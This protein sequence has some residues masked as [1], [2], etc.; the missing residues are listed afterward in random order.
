MLPPKKKGI[1]VGDQVL[2]KQGLALTLPLARE[3]GDLGRA[4][5][6]DQGRTGTEVPALEKGEW[7]WG[8]GINKGRRGDIERGKYLR[9]RDIQRG[10][11]LREKTLWK[12]ED[13]KKEDIEREIHWEKRI[14]RG[15]NEYWEKNTLRG[16]KRKT[17][18][19]ENSE[20]NTLPC[21][22]HRPCRFY[23]KTLLCK[24]G[25]RGIWW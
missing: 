20:R 6:I 17:L 25:L 7:D 9:R 16:W 3:R 1:G 12:G 24:P 22:L 10:K 11:L 21:R 15:L 4:F 14:L 2:T 19:G 13:I 8:S 18:R 5:D 23:R